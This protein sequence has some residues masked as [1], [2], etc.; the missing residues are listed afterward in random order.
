MK[1]HIFC[2]LAFAVNAFLTT[3]DEISPD[4]NSP[5]SCVYTRWI[6]YFKSLIVYLVYRDN[7]RSLYQCDLFYLTNVK[8]FFLTLSLIRA[9]AVSCALNLS[10]VMP[11]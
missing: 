8:F 7:N 5:G 10:L 9:T 11:M 6:Y 1:V 3:L 4:G 2:N